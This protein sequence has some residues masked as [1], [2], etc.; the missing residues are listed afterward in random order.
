M[1]RWPLLKLKF[2]PDA[3]LVDKGNNQSPLPFHIWKVWPGSLLMIWNQ[4][5]GSI[6]CTVDRRNKP[7]TRTE[8]YSLRSTK[9]WYHI[10]ERSCDHEVKTLIFLPHVKLLSEMQLSS[11][12]AG[13]PQSWNPNKW[14]VQDKSLKMCSHFSW[15]VPN[16]YIKIK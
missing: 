4:Q 9:S 16:Q 14:K 1:S 8:A 11:F 13:P 10:H 6:G 15:S 5:N 7:S 2:G 12:T 3:I